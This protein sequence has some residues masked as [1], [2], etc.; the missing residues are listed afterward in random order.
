MASDRKTCF[1][2]APIGP[3]GSEVR[4]RSDNLLRH[5]IAPAAAEAGYAVVRA[6]DIAVPGSITTQIIQLTLDSPLV[7]ADLSGR[8]PNVLYELGIRHA[9]RKPVIQIASD[10]VEIPFDIASV[11]TIIVD[12][13]DLDSVTR[14]KTAL[15]AAI[16]HFEKEPDATDSPV[17]AALD[18]KSLQT[19]RHWMEGPDRTLGQSDPLLSTIANFVNDLDSRM[20]GLEYRIN[21]SWRPL[22]GKKDYSRRVF[23]IHGHDGDLK[24]E[25][26]RLLE[27]LDFEPV[28]LHEQPD[29]GR[30]IF[31]KLKGEMADVGFAFV[32]LTP[33]DVGAPGTQQARLMCRARQNVVFEHGLV[34]AALS[35]E[36]VCAIRKGD[37][38]IPSDLHGVL[39]KSVAPGGGIRSIAIDIANELRAAG[40]IVDANKLLT[41]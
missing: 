13:N 20:K 21:R 4:R 34:V 27:R 19:I 30:T 26:A 6:D 12:A 25:L 35:P 33:D 3:A 39:Y 16:R 22:E 11:R 41:L 38:E 17:S 32:L 1:L 2:L 7:I 18:L 23:I 8:N 31:S 28:I 37:V 36:R 15:T 9:A 5:V 24:N 10:S 14:A 40:Y 29:Q